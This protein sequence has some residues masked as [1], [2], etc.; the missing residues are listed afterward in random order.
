MIETQK[1]VR[2]PLYVDSVRV[3]EENFEEV[4]QWCQGNIETEPKG[5][6]ERRFIRSGCISPSFR[7]RHRRSL[8]IGCFTPRRATRSILISHFRTRSIRLIL[9]TF[10]QTILSPSS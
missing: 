3:T 1:Y 10:L 9:R 8:E 2:K 6:D 5:P 4:A 7:V